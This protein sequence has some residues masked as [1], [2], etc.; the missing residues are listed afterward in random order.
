MRA[1]LAVLL[2]PTLVFA[3]DFKD[4]AE[5]RPFLDGVMSSVVKEDV[6]GAF[7]KLKPYWAGLPDAEIEVLI[8]KI[9]DQRRLI[10]PRFGKSLEAR[11]VSQKIAADSVAHF[12]YIEKFEK[13]VLSWHF[14]L[15]RPKE[16]W[17]L[18]SVN[19][20]DRIQALVDRDG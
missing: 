5:V 7:G 15:Y 1:F 8:G 9:T 10:A 2:L 17:Q 20:D 13:H 18:N 19:F 6:R 12:L 11:F 4:L 16:K 14:Y 3:A